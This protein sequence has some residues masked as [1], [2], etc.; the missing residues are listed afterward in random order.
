M[1]STV[2]QPKI[3]IDMN[4][5]STWKSSGWVR[6]AI[7]LGLLY[8]FFVAIGLMGTAFKLL[9]KDAADALINATSNPFMGLMI[10]ILTTAIVQSSSAT[11][12]TIVALVSSGGL[13]IANA[14]PMVMGAN[15]GT[16]VTN[17]LVSMGYIRKG[18][19]FERAFSGA[20]VHDFFNVLTVIILF[21][22]ELTTGYLSR[23]GMALAHFFTGTSSISFESPLKIIIHPTTEALRGFALWATDSHSFASGIVL[24][25]ISFL[26]L[27]TALVLIV[28]TMKTLMLNR[29]E[30]AIDRL[31][32]ANPIFALLVGMILTAIIQSSSITTSLLVPLIA[33]G[34]MSLETAY[35]ITLGANLGT[36]ITA[37]L[38]S[39]AGD[40]NGLAIAFTHFMFNATGTLIFF[41]VPAMRRIPIGL[42][43]ALGKMAV[44][45]KRVAIFFIISLFYIVPFAFFGVSR[46]LGY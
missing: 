12:S 3:G 42:A 20:T 46:L 18:P 25:V 38:A 13:S 16:S 10:G 30:L 14:V 7:L 8:A 9:G 5:N 1:L 32:G 39:L 15:I 21:P 17:L 2:A 19:E 29:L 36:T 4:A 6:A 44:R 11:T 27:F 22:I 43:R 35:P 41:P 34:V 40:V 23:T 24:A 28:R 45:D 31:F 33:A 26:L 37:L